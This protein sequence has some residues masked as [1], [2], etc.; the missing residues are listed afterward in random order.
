MAFPAFVPE[1][2]IVGAVPC[3]TDMEPV[4]IRR[5]PFL[6]LDIPKSPETTADVVKYSVQYDF[7][8][9]CMQIL[10]DFPEI[11]VCAETAVNL[12]EISGIVTMVVGFEDR[13]Q[14]DGTDAE[15]FQVT[16]PIQKFANPGNTLTVVLNRCPTE[17]DRID[18]IKRFVICPHKNTCFL[19]ILML[20]LKILN[21]A[22]LVLEKTKCT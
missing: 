18:L 21:D 11:I 13:V 16:A 14:D 7:D 9:V 19:F 20:E 10:T 15:M 17:A 4:F 6:L 3:K 1:P 8:A 12:F 22:C 5:I 2:I